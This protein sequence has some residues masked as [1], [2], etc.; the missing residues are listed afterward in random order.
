[1]KSTLIFEGIDSKHLR[2]Q[3]SWVLPMTT[4]SRSEQTDVVLAHEFRPEKHP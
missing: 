4:C 2:I 1:M 3:K